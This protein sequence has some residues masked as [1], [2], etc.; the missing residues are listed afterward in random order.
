MSYKLSN[1]SADNF[2]GF[3]EI[4]VSFDPNVSFLTGPNGSGKSTLGLD[5]LWSCMQ[6]V[7]SKAASKDNSPLIAER[8]QVIGK[9]GKTAKTSITLHDTVKGYDI[10]VTRKISKDGLEIHFDTDADITLDQ[11][12]LNEIFNLY[13]VSP[14]KFIELTPKGQSIALGIDL[15]THD[16]KIKSL[17]EEYTLCNRQLKDLGTPVEVEAIDSVDV[18]ALVTEKATRTAFNTEQEAKQAIIENNQEKLD[19]LVQ[20]YKDAAISVE[21]L[22]PLF[23][24]VEPFRSKE[25]VSMGAA[26]IRSS[27]SALCLTLEDL[28]ARYTLIV[29]ENLP[30]IE[31]GTAYIAS[32]P[33]PLDLLDIVELDEQIA[34]ASSINV[35]ASQYEAYVKAVEKRESLITALEDNKTEQKKMEEARTK[36]IQSFNLPFADLTINEDGEL[37]LQ[38][39][40]LKESY[41]SAGELIKTVP[42]LIIASMKS[43][44]RAINFPYVYVSDFSLLDIKNQQ[45]IVEFFKANDIQCVL[46]IVDEKVGTE[47]NH[48]YLKDNHIIT[49]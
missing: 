23:A 37:L 15:S 40:Y 1:V 46:E 3:D 11:R 16:T 12:F 39:R 49:E 31:K 30:R 9:S 45:E 19:D 36:K 43:Q 8:Y 22:T 21:E 48:I 42:M 47:K 13:L 33:K 29:Q 6:G 17:K 25:Y 34:N 28:I 26:S 10:K 7:G 41:W 44:G 20:T 32:L 2:K 38:G 18:T 27:F 14:K 35:L 5:I 24:S 4:S